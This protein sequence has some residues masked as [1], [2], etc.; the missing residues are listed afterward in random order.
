MAKNLAKIHEYLECKSRRRPFKWGVFDCCLFACDIIVI[1]GGSDFAAEV[2][3][4][5]TT[6]IGSQRI[7]KKYF[8]TLEDAFS[9]LESVPFNFAQRGD[10]TLFD[11]PEGPLMA[12][13][14]NEGYMGISATQGLGLIVVKG[15]PVRTW[16][17]G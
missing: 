13:K 11:T 6:A 4:R 12:M 16:R 8:G 17:V 14:W 3:G 7:I 10:F 15:T 2:R 5:Y 9:S 1:C